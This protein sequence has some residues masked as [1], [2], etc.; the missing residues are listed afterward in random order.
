MKKF[1]V[2]FFLSH[3][4]AICFTMIFVI[5]FIIYFTCVS[6]IALF[7]NYFFIDLFTVKNCIGIAMLMNI[8]VIIAGKDKILKKIDKAYREALDLVKK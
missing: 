1:F 3:I 6:A 7:I 4:K 2:T 5:N 8:L